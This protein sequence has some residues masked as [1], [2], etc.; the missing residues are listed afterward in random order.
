MSREDRLQAL[1]Q[2]EASVDQL[3]R[4]KLDLQA[5]VAQLNAEVQT[6]KERLEATQT[7]LVDTTQEQQLKVIAEAIANDPDLTQVAKKIFSKLSRDIAKS[8]AQLQT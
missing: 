5:R 1:V 4:Q 3:L 6:L 7:Q 2:L 8:I